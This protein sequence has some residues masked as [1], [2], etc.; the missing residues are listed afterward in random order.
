VLEAP[1]DRLARGAM[2]W[3]A[4][5]AGVAIEQSMLGATH[6]CANPLTARYGTTH[7]VAIAV[8]LP[9]VVRWNAEVVGDR[10]AELLVARP[11]STSARDHFMRATASPKPATNPR[12]RRRESPARRESDSASTATEAG[13]QLASR[14]EELRHDGRCRPA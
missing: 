13:E 9:H 4:H 7:G 3:G 11:F 1:D 8:M 5:E 12:E 10:Y 14:L 2:L 6:A